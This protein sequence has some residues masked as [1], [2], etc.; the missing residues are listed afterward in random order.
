M[1]FPKVSS[2]F[3][4]VSTILL[5]G[6]VWLLLF[7]GCGYFSGKKAGDLL[8]ARSG[9]AKLYR[10]QLTGM[11]NPETTAQDSI[12]I[13]N[14][15]VENWVRRQILLQQA[16]FEPNNQMPGIEQ[17]LQDYKESLLIHNF[18]QQML[19]AF[20]DT[21]INQDEIASYYEQNK[22]NFLLEDNILKA[23]FVIT[24]KGETRKDSVKL[25]LKKTDEFSQQTLDNL[26]KKHQWPSSLPHSW[27][28]W[29]DL[30]KQIPLEDN[31]FNLIS[32]NRFYQNSDAVNS[33]F[34]S[35]E[36]VVS[37]GE[38]APLDYCMTEIKKIIVHKRSL[39]YLRQTKNRYYKEAL[40]KG[41]IEIFRQP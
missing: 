27:K 29:D 30:K 9:N 39:E 8:I 5:Y 18:E 32:R 26:T 37:R 24:P 38:P 41:L 22:T 15:Y 1:C 23:A 36:A 35:A 31:D 14:Q 11:V 3:C 17:Q 12:Q 20:A 25:L 19:G 16:E 21:L 34:L 13:I 4:T 6:A 40:N 28:T 7:N 2:F 10:S 33:Y